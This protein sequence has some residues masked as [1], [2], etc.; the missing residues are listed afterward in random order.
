M[1]TAT[2]AVST[3]PAPVVRRRTGDGLGNHQLSRELLAQIAAD[4]ADVDA[5]RG[6]L[7]PL[8]R[9]LA[10]AGRGDLGLPGSNGTL[11]EQAAVIAGIAQGCVTSAFSLWAHRI[12]TE[13]VA[14]YGTAT[15][16]ALATTLRTAERPGVSAMATAFRAAAGTEPLPITF[17][18][19]GDHLV[20]DGTIRWASNLYSDAVIV[21]AARAAHSTDPFTAAHLVVAVPANTPGVSIQPAD[22]LLALNSSRS[23]SVH[24]AKVRVPVGHIVTDDFAGFITDVKPTFLALQAAF[25][26]GLATAALAAT[27]PPQGAASVFAEHH[28]ALVTERHGLEDRLGRLCDQIATTPDPAFRRSI[29]RAAVQLRLDTGLHAGLAT[30]LELRL[31]GGRGFVAA[32][33]TARRVREALFIPIQSPTESELRWELLP[34]V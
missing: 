6:D 30:N 7:R 9:E 32:S 19:D 5:H 33:A 29:G 10:A 24:L 14:T 15:T 23:G 12:A 17:A 13:Y 11:T 21:T 28:E 34:S 1:S 20:L 8:L 22:D 18:H 3:A 16:A 26:L 25:C 27:A 31:A 4:A 2:Q